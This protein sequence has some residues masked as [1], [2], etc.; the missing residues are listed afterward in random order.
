[1]VGRAAAALH[2]RPCRADTER[3]DRR[4]GRPR[5]QMVVQRAA[6]S[7]VSH[8][9]VRE[10]SAV[11]WHYLLVLRLR[12]AVRWTTK[13]R[14]SLAGRLPVSTCQAEATGFRRALLASR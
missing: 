2:Q 10:W 4:P 14:H 1:M 5:R 6:K 8:E 12:K 13:G 7:I 3:D 11:V 9:R